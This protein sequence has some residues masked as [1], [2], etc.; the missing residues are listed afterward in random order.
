MVPKTVTVFGG[1]EHFK[2]VTVLLL[3]Y[4][5]VV[6]EPVVKTIPTHFDQILKRL[7][8]FSI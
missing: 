6:F 3:K 5:L 4:T 8:I 2:M 7:K 1:F